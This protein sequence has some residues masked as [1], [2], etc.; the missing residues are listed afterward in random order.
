VQFKFKRSQ[1]PSMSARMRVMTVFPVCWFTKGL[2][3]NIIK[4][5]RMFQFLTLGVRPSSTAS[6]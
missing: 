4:N 1:P 2:D 5:A 6:S 3:R